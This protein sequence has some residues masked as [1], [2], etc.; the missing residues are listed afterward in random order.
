MLL[1]A[2]FTNFYCIAPV[3]TLNQSMAVQ[4]HTAKVQFQVRSGQ[5]QTGQTGQFQRPERGISKTDRERKIN[6]KTHVR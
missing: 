4:I 3:L 1:F 5:F 2:L 6:G